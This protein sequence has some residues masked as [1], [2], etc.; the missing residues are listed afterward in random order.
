MGNSGFSYNDMVGTDGDSSY[1]KFEQVITKLKPVNFIGGQASITYLQVAFNPNKWQLG[2]KFSEV[3]SLHSSYTKEMAE[4]LWYGNTRFIGR[5]INLAPEFEAVRYFDLSI[6]KSVQFGGWKVGG[7]IKYLEGVSAISVQG[8]KLEVYTDPNSFAIH[9]NSDITINQSN[10]N[11]L[12]RLGNMPEKWFQNPGYGLDIGVSRD[13]KSGFALN[14]SVVGIG[15]IHWRSN[16]KSLTNQN[17]LVFEG[18]ELSGFVLGDSLG[19][20]NYLDSIERKLKF[21]KAKSKFNSPLIPKFNLG[22]TIPI[23]QSWS[24]NLLFQYQRIGRMNM[25]SSSIAIKRA[26]I[27]DAHKLDL[28][29]HYTYRN[30]EPLNLGLSGVYRINFMQVFLLSDNLLSWLSPKAVVPISQFDKKSDLNLIIPKRI[31]SISFR[32]GINILF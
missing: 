10:P 7:T 1:L 3:L 29:V 13:F 25:L 2:L 9:L 26:F 5:E 22:G 14:A 27:Y 6:N 4:F 28:S 24:G 8:N 20:E 15:M 18:L 23:S 17:S 19:L 12:T 21:K 11:R 31:K 16:V 32:A 30:R